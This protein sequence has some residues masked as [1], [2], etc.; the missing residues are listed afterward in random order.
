[1]VLRAFF[2]IMLLGEIFDFGA[3]FTLFQFDIILT[4][5]SIIDFI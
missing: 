4:A 1:M 5:I 2:N 3:S